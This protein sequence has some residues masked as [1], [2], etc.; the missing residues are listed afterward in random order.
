M[1]PPLRSAVA[2]TLRV[3]PNDSSSSW[4]TVQSYVAP[5]EAVNLFGVRATR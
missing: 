5:F 4:L 2:S 3:F 1:P